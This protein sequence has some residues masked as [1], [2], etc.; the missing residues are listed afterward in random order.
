MV[1]DGV[2]VLGGLFCAAALVATAPVSA[3]INSSMA[4]SESVAASVGSASDSLVGSSRSSVG[5]TKQAAGKYRVVA[6]LEVPGRPERLRLQ[7]EPLADGRGMQH[8]LE[9]PRRTAERHGLGVGMEVS[10]LARPWGLE[11]ALAATRTAFFLVV[12]DEA[13]DEFAVRALRT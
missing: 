10:A 4:S 5:G 12:D 1:R 8:G 7:L 9:L 13:L 11:Y 2:V 3:T 6:L